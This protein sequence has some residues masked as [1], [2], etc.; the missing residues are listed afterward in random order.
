V[1]VNHHSLSDF[2]VDHEA[3]LDQLLTD[4][5]ATLVEAKAVTLDRVAQDGMRVRASAGSSSFRRR[6]RIEERQRQAKED[7]RCA[8]SSTEIRMPVGN[9][10]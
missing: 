5:V 6:A 7:R 10:K 8:R 9:E 3:E 1:S 4:G 2:R